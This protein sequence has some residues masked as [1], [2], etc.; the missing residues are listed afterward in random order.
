MARKLQVSPYVRKTILSLFVGMRVSMRAYLNCHTQ[1]TRVHHNTPSS[2]L[3]TFI[4][5]VCAKAKSLEVSCLQVNENLRFHLFLIHTHKH[6]KLTETWTLQIVVTYCW[7]RKEGRFE[8]F[9]LLRE[10]KKKK[11]KQPR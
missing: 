9:C 6:S 10:N 2:G 1:S 11:A 3:S 4:L 5:Q 7:G 8:V